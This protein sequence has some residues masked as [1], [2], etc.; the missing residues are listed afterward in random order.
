[1][2]A[3]DL[4]IKT[5]QY[6]LAG[7]YKKQKGLGMREKIIVPSSDRILVDFVPNMYPLH[8]SQHDFLSSPDVKSPAFWAGMENAYFEKIYYKRE[9]AVLKLG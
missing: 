6:F 4:W 2:E 3:S 5:K 7:I 9:S 1:L 8:L